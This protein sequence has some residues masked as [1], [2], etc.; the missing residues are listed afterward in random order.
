M[1]LSEAPSGL[2]S[3]MLRLLNDASCGSSLDAGSITH[4]TEHWPCVP[5]AQFTLRQCIGFWEGQA[6]ALLLEH[7]LPGHH[8]IKVGVSP[9]LSLPFGSPSHPFPPPFFHLFHNPPLL[10]GR[11]PFAPFLCTVQQCFSCQL[12][13]QVNLICSCTNT[14][15]PL[16]KSQRL[17][18]TGQTKQRSLLR[19][20]PETVRDWRWG[21]RNALLS[22]SL[23]NIP[24]TGCSSDA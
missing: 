6:Q 19:K 23:C 17:S 5:L 21:E 22:T 13:A 11:E 15:K 2:L 7:L 18:T 20:L 14:L 10:A 24:N 16:S 8:Q 12:R 1:R 3:F 4:S 9:V